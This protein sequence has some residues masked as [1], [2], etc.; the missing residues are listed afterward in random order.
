MVHFTTGELVSFG[1]RGQQLDVTFPSLHA[2]ADLLSLGYSLLILLE[3]QNTSFS[4]L[5]YL[6]FF[7]NRHI[8][9]PNWENCPRASAKFDP[10]LHA[11]YFEIR[12]PPDLPPHTR[13]H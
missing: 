9:T 5:H 4:E 12:L 6:L 11:T 2:R 1:L 7:L 3:L 8:H 10:R 13:Q